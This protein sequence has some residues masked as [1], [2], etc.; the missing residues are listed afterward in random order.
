MGRVRKSSRLGKK[1][2]INTT[3]YGKKNRKKYNK[4]GYTIKMSN[5][6]ERWNKGL[7]MKTNLRNLGLV[8]DINSDIKPFGK[9][10]KQ[11]TGD[12]IE[13]MDIAEAVASV[14]PTIA[15]ETESVPPAVKSKRL[16]GGLKARTLHEEFQTRSKRLVRK[17]C[18][19]ST[20]ESEYLAPLIQKHGTNYTKMY[21]DKGNYD[22]LTEKQLQKKCQELLMSRETR[23][24]KKFKELDLIA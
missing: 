2:K 12:N 16:I 3:K 5:V 19:L 21:R 1:G 22:Q 4:S 20:I 14:S 13:F 11:K 18:H 17:T 10:D 15:T 8:Y 23:H 9:K 6:R 24:L 7:T